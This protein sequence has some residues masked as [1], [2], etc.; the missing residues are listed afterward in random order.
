MDLEPKYNIG[1][2]SLKITVTKT[3]TKFYFYYK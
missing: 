2:R 3:L 1:G